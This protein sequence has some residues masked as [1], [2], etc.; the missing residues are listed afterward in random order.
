M[1]RRLGLPPGG[2]GCVE[3]DLGE[4]ELEQSGGELVAA[5][6]KKAIECLKRFGPTGE[7]DPDAQP[8]HLGRP[9][10]E[11]VGAGLRVGELVETAGDGLSLAQ[12]TAGGLLGR[13]RRRGCGLGCGR[14]LDSLRQPLAELVRALGAGRPQDRGAVGRGL[15]HL[16][17]DGLGLGLERLLQLAVAFGAKE[18]LEDLFAFP[19]AGLQQLLEL[20]LGQHDH[21]AELHAA[22]AEDALDLFGDV[23]RLDGQ[24]RAFGVGVVGRRRAAVPQ[25]GARVLDGEAVAAALGPLLPGA[26]LY[27][28]ALAGDREIE[29]HFGAQRRV[30]VVGAHVAALPGTRIVR[31]AAARVA[32]QGEGHGVEDGGLAGAGGPVDEKEAVGTE[33]REVEDLAVAVGA[34]GLHDED[35]WLHGRSLAATAAAGGRRVGGLMTRAG[36]VRAARGQPQRRRPRWPKAA[37]L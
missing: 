11:G 35:L 13:R 16:A 9:G 22:K 7:V 24:R 25:G 27:P 1:E 30:G 6:V 34:E 20:A 32:V 23:G 15:L 21:L 29:S 31:R 37:R 17:L 4:L 2:R 3:G 26:A 10:G 14:S 28:V 12:L 36:A 8:L 18:A 33:L 5:V 19:A